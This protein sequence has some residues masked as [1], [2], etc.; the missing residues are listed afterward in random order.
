MGEKYDIEMGTISK[1]KEKY[2]MDECFELDL[3]VPLLLWCWKR[4]WL[5]DPMFP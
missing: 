5:R 4:S 3:L 1:P 2:T